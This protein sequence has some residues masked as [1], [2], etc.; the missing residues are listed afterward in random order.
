MNLTSHIFIRAVC[1]AQDRY[2]SCCHNVNS[3][4]TFAIDK[5]KS[6]IS[7]IV[8][9]IIVIIVAI[10]IFTCRCNIKLRKKSFTHDV[11]VEVNYSKKNTMLK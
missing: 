1:N 2:Q 4:N 9:V 3:V 7:K 8:T 6:T 5:Y 10:N 11:T